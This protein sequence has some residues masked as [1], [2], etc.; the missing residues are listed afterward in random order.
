M[1]YKVKELLFNRNLV[2][3]FMFFW[4]KIRGVDLFVEES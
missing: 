1:V 3:G 2:Y 4:M